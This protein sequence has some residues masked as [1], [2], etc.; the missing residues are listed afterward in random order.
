M[1]DKWLDGI[2]TSIKSIDLNAATY[3]DASRLSY[4]LNDYID[5]VATYDGGKL[6]LTKIK[7]AA[8]K[9]RTLSL[10]VPKG[11]MTAIQRD[12]IEAARVRAQA[13]GVDLQSDRILRGTHV[14]RRLPEERHRIL[15]HY[16][17]N[18][19][20]LLSRNRTG[21]RRFHLGHKLASSSTADNNARG[22]PSVP[23]LKRNEWPAPVVLKYKGKNLVS[24]RAWHAMLGC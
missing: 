17:T 7:S 2:V 13:F 19:R 15:A 10:A 20:R 24:I 21:R 8:I 14:L 16:G 23:M 4:R 1:I 11:S 6:G 12:A 9:G 5:K 3:Q 22:N 18:G